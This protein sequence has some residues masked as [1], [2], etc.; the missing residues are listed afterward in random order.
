MLR[1]R[2]VQWVVMGIMLLGLP[3]AGILLAGKPVGPYLQFPPLTRY[4]A[5]APF[6]W[7][8]FAFYAA[9]NMAAVLLI[10][11]LIAIGRKRGRS[12][13]IDRKY[14]IPWWGRLGMVVMI[15]GW[16]LAWTRLAWFAPWQHHTFVLPWIGYILLVNGLCVQRTGRSL[17][18]DAPVR[19]WALFPVSALFWW[20]FEYLNRFVQ[21]WY[22]LGV[23][24]FG[25]AAY[26]AF[27][28]LAFATVLPAVL[29]TYRLIL[30][31]GIFDP[32]LR[33]VMPVRISRPRTAAMAVFISAALGLFFLGLYPS[34]LFA[35]LWISPLLIL[36]ALQTLSD[37]PT[38]FT[39][40]KTGDWHPLVAAALAALVCGL[41][42]E[43]WNIG[44]LAQ[45]QYSLPFVDRFRIFAMPILGYGGYLP[46]GLQC[47]VAG[48]MV[49][50]R[51][52]LSL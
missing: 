24:H 10:V 21:N 49:L 23:D 3:L 42:W 2:A 7:A 17:L 41:F 13:R 9:V 38:I 30:S 12:V 34:W 20:F 47:L 26:V 29:S 31:F 43:L 50:G 15:A 37:R 40:L 39:P 8:V 32:G 6:S 48:E 51:R 16:L 35:L 36:I 52:V 33:R 18:T 25:T 14:R 27:A 46:F 22:Y 5:H 11:Y 19:F 4:V 44:S 1:S 45:W 28:T